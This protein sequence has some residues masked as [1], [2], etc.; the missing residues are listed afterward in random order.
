MAQ[1]PYAPVVAQVPGKRKTSPIVWVLVI[2]L[3]LFV[4]GGLTI[5]GLGFFVMHKVKQAG[6]DP[7]LMQ[8][9][10][11]LAVSKLVAATN[12]DVEVLSTDEGAGTITFR[13]KRT[14]KVSTITFDQ[15]KN[16]KFSITAQDDQGKNATLDFGG[17]AKGI[18]EWVPS[19]P[20]GSEPKSTFSASAD[21]GKVSGSFTFTTSD[22]QDRVMSFYQD[23]FKEL[24]L[25]TTNVTSP[26]GGSIIGTNDDT[27]R[28]LIVLVGNDSPITV[29]VTYA[30]K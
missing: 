17:S 28:S 20:G 23:K 15:A 12:P 14:G 13:D 19:Y 2:V 26:T 1:Q 30:V 4:L 27:K 29:S 3:G 9:N 25:K 22:P 11:G 18:P 8:R 16:G 10:P 7:E 21:G 24:G 6:L 5:V